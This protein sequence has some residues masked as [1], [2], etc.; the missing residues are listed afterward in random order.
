MLQIVSKGM[1]ISL[2]H[3]LN[4]FSQKTTGLKPYNGK[5]TI[6][7]DMPAPNRPWYCQ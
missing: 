1:R 6:I 5:V 4:I 7:K 2:C 3:K